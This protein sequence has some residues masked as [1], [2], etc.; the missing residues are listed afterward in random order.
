[1]DPNNPEN[2]NKSTPDQQNASNSGQNSTSDR[3]STADHTN[4]SDQND[5][6]AD[7]TNNSDQ[8]NS[9]A[10]HTNNTTGQNIATADQNAGTSDH[11][12][13]ASNQQTATTDQEHQRATGERQT[14]G[15]P[16]G[17]G[18]AK[19]QKTP[20]GLLGLGGYGSDVSSSDD[21]NLD[22]SD[23]DDGSDPNEGV[24]EFVEADEADAADDVL[25][26]DMAA[27][28]DATSDHNNNPDHETTTDHTVDSDQDPIPICRLY[29]GTPL[30]GVDPRIAR[31]VDGRV[32]FANRSTLIRPSKAAAGSAE[33]RW[34]IIDEINGRLP[35]SLLARITWVDESEGRALAVKESKRAEDRQR[36]MSQQ[37][38]SIAGHVERAALNQE[39][40][41]QPDRPDPQQLASW[42]ISSFRCGRAVTLA[43]LADQIGAEARAV[44]AAQA[45]T[46]GQP[47]TSAHNTSTTDQ[48]IAANSTILATSLLSEAV[49][50]LP[51]TASWVE[52]YC[53]AIS[54]HYQYSTVETH[55]FTQE[56]MRRLAGPERPHTFPAA[57]PQDPG[58]STSGQ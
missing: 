27:E 23:A 40:S 50:L 47:T 41:D 28:K 56:V 38:G 49:E 25:F 31:A 18:R 34:E 6:T 37:L 11:T 9:T 8:N 1:M 58:A 17:K 33:R 43:W 39:D 52:Q 53:M 26:A 32:L 24:Q 4:N 15:P 12:N 10:D 55:S 7:H 22:V 51:A 13:T 3:N 14:Q 45:A 19:R 42:T 2:N 16:Q 29:G 48:V 5:S 21:S 46:S 44:A 35:P 30:T 20:S 36:S 57:P 54:N